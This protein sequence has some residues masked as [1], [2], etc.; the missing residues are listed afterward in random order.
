VHIRANLEQERSGRHDG[1]AA[2]HEAR[3]VYRRINNDE[4]GDQ[5]PVLAMAG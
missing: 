3:D 2:R 1:G 4:G 5:P